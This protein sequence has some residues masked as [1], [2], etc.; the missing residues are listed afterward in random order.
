MN[1][2]SMVVGLVAVL[3]AVF[4]VMVIKALYAIVGLLG[5]IN[6]KLAHFMPDRP[7]D[8]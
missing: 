2:D 3:C 8:Y 1:I 4:G 7:P 6:S 5:S